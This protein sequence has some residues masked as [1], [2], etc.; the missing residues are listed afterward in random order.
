MTNLTDRYL[1]A[2]AYIS[3]YEIDHPQL[4]RDSEVDSARTT[5]VLVSEL[6]RMRAKIRALADEYQRIG[7]GRIPSY[8]EG[9]TVAA[10]LRELIA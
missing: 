10:E 5:L 2:L 7:E 3:Q 4:H 9:C 1:D 8:E 6:K